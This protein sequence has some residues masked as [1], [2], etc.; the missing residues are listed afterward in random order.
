MS[1]DKIRY[2]LGIGFIALGFIFLL[3]KS[4]LLGFSLVSAAEL[5]WP[6]FFV[7][8]GALEV[9]DKR[10]TFGVILVTV[11]IIAQISKLT[12]WGFWSLF[13]PV[14]FIGAGLALL[15]KEFSRRCFPAE[16]AE[17]AETMERDA[18]ERETE[19]VEAEEAEIIE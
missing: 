5:F 17:T 13:W 4:E 12:T 1:I 15:N 10:K 14:F 9:V 6:L 7:F 3:E 8:W 19:R 11:G 2:Y 16:T 18:G